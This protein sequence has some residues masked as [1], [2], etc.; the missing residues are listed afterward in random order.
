MHEMCKSTDG[1]VVIKQQLI[2]FKRGTTRQ[3][4]L[5]YMLALQF[6]SM[7]NSAS[8]VVCC[9]KFNAAVDTTTRL[10]FQWRLDCRFELWG[11]SCMYW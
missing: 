1:I 11:R 5:C 2:H 6:L 8:Y 4:I 7:A 10:L 3:T 9:V